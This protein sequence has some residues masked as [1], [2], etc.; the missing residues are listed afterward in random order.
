MTQKVKGLH[1]G[2]KAATDKAKISSDR[3]EMSHLVNLFLYHLGKISN[4]LIAPY[5]ASKFA[6]DGFFSSIRK[7]YSVAKVNVSITLCILGLINTGK[8]KRLE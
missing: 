8:D 6:L 1:R 4:P 7:E 5:A 3:A 2:Y